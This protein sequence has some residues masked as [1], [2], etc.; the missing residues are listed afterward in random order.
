MTTKNKVEPQKQSFKTT[1]L[2]D[3]HDDPAGAKTSEG[4]PTIAVRLE[5]ME[6]LPHR[7]A[8]LHWIAFTLSLL[9]LIL[10]STWVFS[11]RE[12]VPMGWVLLDVGLGVVF[13]I[14]LFTRSGFRQDKGLYLRTRFIDFIAI[15]PAL[16][17]MVM[18]YPG[19]PRYPCPGP[20]PRRRVCTADRPGPAGGDRGRD[21]GHGAW[22]YYCP[23]S[24]RHG[25]DQL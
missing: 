2:K 5:E 7:N 15:V 11:S 4:V 12:L 16:V 13:A 17:R 10:L 20:F 9:S 25:P 21:N 19:R 23:H 18:D 8:A 3:E 14:E 6:A 24:G 1:T 22:A